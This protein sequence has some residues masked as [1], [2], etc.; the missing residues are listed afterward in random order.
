MTATL[1]ACNIFRLIYDLQQAEEYSG[2][3]GLEYYP[4]VPLGQT[5]GAVREL[6]N[7]P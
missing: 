1:L 7:F 2:Y 3:V 4:T 5:M 6:A